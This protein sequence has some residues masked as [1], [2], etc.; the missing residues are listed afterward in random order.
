MKKKIIGV[1]VM[2]AIAVTAGWN[3]SQEK[4]EMQLSDLALSNVEALA[5]SESSGDFTAATGCV[6]VLYSASCNGKDGRTHSYAVRQ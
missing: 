4:N 6:A 1:A 2:A 3:M 5:N